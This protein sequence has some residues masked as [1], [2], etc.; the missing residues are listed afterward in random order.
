MAITDITKTAIIDELVLGGIAW[1]GRMDEDDFLSRLYPMADLPSTDHRF[2]NAAGDVWQHRVN[3]P[4]DWDDD[5]VFYDPR[6]ELLHGGDEPFLRFLAE[7]VHPR[8]R[9]DRAE[10]DELARAYNR[11]LRHDGYELVVVSQISGRNVYAPRSLLTVPAV[12]REV[13]RAGEVGDRD[14]LVQQITRMETSIETDPELA[15]GTAKEL[16][17]T[18]CK[19]ILQARNVEIDKRWDVPKLMKQT[20]MVSSAHP[21]GSAGRRPSRT[22]H[23]PD[24]RQSG[25]AGRGH[26]R[27][28]ELLRHRTRQGTWARGTGAS[29]RAPRRRR[30]SHPGH[31]PVRH[32]AGSRRAP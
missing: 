15:I 28:A 16:V 9:P 4:M 7:T 17:E 19:T 25:V 20:A 29:P 27:A 1:A 18:A 23:P 3:N 26:G 22:Y 24:S 30:C 8:V 6:F 14:Y 21:R 11:H 12:L 31:L 13:E 5:W 32:R 10:A 2:D